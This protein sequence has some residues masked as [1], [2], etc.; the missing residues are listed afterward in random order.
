MSSISQDTLKQSQ[1][2]QAIN[3]ELQ[4]SQNSEG[5]FGPLNTTS[6]ALRQELQ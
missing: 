6:K 4:I 5:L 1:C 2:P 3:P